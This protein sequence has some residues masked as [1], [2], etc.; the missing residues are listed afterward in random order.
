MN[1]RIF[2]GAAAMALGMIFTATLAFSQAP[3]GEPQSPGWFLQGSAP[4]PGGRLVV[5]PGGRVIPTAGGAGG[6]RG[7]PLAAI[8]VPAAG[9]VPGCNHSPL[10]GNRLGGAR[11]A[12]QR[13]EWKQTM[14]YTYAY[15]VDLPEV[16]GGV[17]AVQIDSKGNMWVFQRSAA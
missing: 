15:P 8:P 5:G 4:D 7:G 2:T 6:G 1:G 3:A 12:L 11:S 13:V 17:S 16:G 9:G 14:G 10:C